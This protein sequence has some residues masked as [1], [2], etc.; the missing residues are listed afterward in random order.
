MDIGRWSFSINTGMRGNGR[1]G[2]GFLQGGF[3]SHQQ[4]VIEVFTFQ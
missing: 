4:E 3:Y 2:T 1:H